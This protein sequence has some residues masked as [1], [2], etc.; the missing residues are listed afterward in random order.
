MLA[1]TCLRL[2]ASRRHRNSLIMPTASISNSA[3]TSTSKGWRT[4]RRSSRSAH[5]PS[6]RACVWSTARSVTLARKRHTRCISA[7][8]TT[9]ASTVWRCSSAARARMSSC[10]TG[11]AAVSWR[12]MGTRTT[13]SRPGTPS[14]PPAAAART[15]KGLPRARCGAQARH[16]RYRRARRGAQ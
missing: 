7:L 6:A 16:G 15:G 2:S 14:S 13:P 10:A 3:R 12:T 8:K 9:C 4:R 11:A 5:V 1:V